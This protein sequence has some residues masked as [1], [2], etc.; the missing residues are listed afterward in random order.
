MILIV[1]LESLVGRGGR[2]LGLGLAA[3]GE[4][5]GRRGLE[6]RMGNGNEVVGNGND[7]GEKNGEG[8]SCSGFTARRGGTVLTL[9]TSLQASKLH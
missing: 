3:A 5:R 2:I 1:D 9:K 7:A 6:G 4:G 8:G